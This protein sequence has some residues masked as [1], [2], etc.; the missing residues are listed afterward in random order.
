MT[1]MLLIIHMLL[2]V[3]LIGS[4]THQT[5]GALWPVRARADN[6]VARYRATKGAAYVNAIVVLYLAT[7]LL[8]AI[9]YPTYRIGARV[10]MESLRMYPYVGSFELKE[11]VVAM[12]LGLLPAYWWLWRE[13]Q[14]SDHRVSRIVVTTM[15]AV[16]VWY[17]FLVGHLLNNIKGV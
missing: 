1:I 3:A 9:L 12:G 17:A 11:H 6:F 16:I 4:V 2:A 5:V 13:P 14:A 15:L 8:G 10:F 7:A